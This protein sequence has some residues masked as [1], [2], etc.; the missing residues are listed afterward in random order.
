MAGQIITTGKRGAIAVLTIDMAD[1]AM[2][3]LNDASMAALDAAVS[4]A[5]ADAAVAGIVITSGKPAFVAGADLTVMEGFAAR[6]ARPEQ[7]LD[8]VARLNTVFRRIETGGKPVVGAATGTALG[9]G[10]ELLLACHYRV[11]VDDPKARFGLPEVGLGLLPGLGGT[12]RLPRLIGIAAALPVLLEGRP[13]DAQTALKAGVLN[14][15]VPAGGLVDAAIAALEAGR[16]PSQQPWDVKGFRVPGGGPMQ[17]KVAETFVAAN[18][19]INAARKEGVEAPLAILRAVFEGAN[20]PFEKGLAIENRHFVRLVQGN[21]AQNMIR[22]GFFARQAADKLARRPAGIAPR[23]MQRIGVLGVGLMGSGIAQV[24]AEAGYQVVMVDRS[25]EI[26]AAAVARIGDGLQADVAKGRRSVTSAQS[27]LSRLSAGTAHADF[28]D[29]D[30]VVEAVLEDTEVKRAAIRS[31][32]AVLKPDA[33]FAT[34]TSALPIDSLA[35]ASIRADRLI[36][37]HFFSPVPKMALVEVIRGS[38]TTD[39]T[40]AW[41]LDYVKAIRKTPI[42]VNDGYGFYTTRCVDAY[43]REGLHLV[44]DG[45]DPVLIERAG[46]AIGM[47]VGPLT[48]MDEVGIDVMEHIAHFFRE[49]EAGDWADDRH[50]VNVLIERLVAAGRKGRKAGTG[51]FAYTEGA[52]HLDRPFIRTLV[53]KPQAE[54]IGFDEIA[55]RLFYTQL[56]EARRCEADGVIT[57][58]A[59]ADLGAVL[60]WAFPIWKGGPLQ[61]IEDIGPEAFARNCAALVAR[62]GARFALPPASGAA[63][64]AAE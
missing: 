14:E 46:E 57:D 49:N 2:N 3:V 24:S 52:K 17:L 5:L 55:E 10:L 37:L 1:R 29:C 19:R 62:A 53:I 59:E 20:L 32:E 11:A 23:P 35:P 38:A 26:A 25:P 30:M 48:L 39:E 18:A 12:Q 50:A 21:S 6:N 45:V 64:Q 44:A 63:R 33:I 16:V 22:T 51:M 56:V 9:G 42:V 8:W 41:S 43:V 28:A 15:V 34:N 31:V 7:V 60:G 47:P 40:L 58:R 27:I 36:G 61:A 54:P 13:V 4:D